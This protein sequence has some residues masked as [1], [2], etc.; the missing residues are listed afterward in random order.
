M[1]SIGLIYK[2]WTNTQNNK[3]GQRLPFGIYLFIS[4][5]MTKCI[6]F[7]YY[8]YLNINCYEEKNRN[9]NSCIDVS[10]TNN[11]GIMCCYSSY[12]NSLKD[13]SHQKPIPCRL[14]TSPRNMFTTCYLSQVSL[15]PIMDI[16]KRFILMVQYRRI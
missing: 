12:C 15:R 14:Q 10:Y 4:Y 1:Q 13:Y 6:P 8:N 2:N 3:G 5:I 11:N 16:Q 7:R 9:N